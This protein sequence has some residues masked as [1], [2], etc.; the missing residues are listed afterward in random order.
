MEERGLSTKSGGEFPELDIVRRSLSCLANS[1]QWIPFLYIVARGPRNLPRDV[2]H[3]YLPFSL[4]LFIS[5]YVHVLVRQIDKRGK[6]SVGPWERG[7][8]ALTV[9]SYQP[10]S[11][12][13]PISDFIW[14]LCLDANYTSLDSDK[15]LLCSQDESYTERL[16]AVPLERL[17][18]RF[19]RK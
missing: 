3:A 6:D 9:E 18:P 4:C 5:I 8:V 19:Q 10:Q 16:R 7:W 2:W 1:E 17:S 14:K 15:L 11:V 12:E 13:I